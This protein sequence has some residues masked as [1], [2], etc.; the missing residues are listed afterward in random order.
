MVF[1]EG[2]S[3]AQPLYEVVAELANEWN[4]NDNVGLVV[5][6]TYPEQ[7]HRVRKICPSMIFLIP[8]I[9]FQGGDIGETVSSAIDSKGGGF[10]LSSS[11]QIMYAA[12][13]ADGMLA[14]DEA[15]KQRMREMAISVRDEINYHIAK[16]LK[17]HPVHQLSTA[18]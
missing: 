18:N 16:A 9:G 3:E 2:A 13:N 17:N 4:Y 10:I 12:K 1:R 14:T 7:I 5:G 8:G 15:A 6:A 11:R